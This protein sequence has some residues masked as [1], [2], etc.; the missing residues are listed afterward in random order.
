MRM[1]REIWIEHPKKSYWKKTKN[2]FCFFLKTAYFSKE[3]WRKLSKLSKKN[4]VSS[5]NFG[6]WWKKILR[7]IFPC[8]NPNFDYSGENWLFCEG[9]GSGGESLNNEK[10]LRKTQWIILFHPLFWDNWTNDQ[11]Y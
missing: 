6:R 1:N 9:D 5:K 7:V 2:I 10:I 3:G 4:E 11:N 8:I